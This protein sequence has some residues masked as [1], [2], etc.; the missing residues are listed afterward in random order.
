M[1]EALKRLERLEAELTGLPADRREAELRS[2]PTLDGMI[3]Q[4][5]LIEHINWFEATDKK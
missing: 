3:L 4:Y 1:V 5:R 2:L